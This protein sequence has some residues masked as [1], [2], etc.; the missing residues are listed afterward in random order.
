[1]KGICLTWS[2]GFL[3]IVKCFERHCLLFIRVKKGNFL[4]LT[5][6][7]TWWRN[8]FRIIGLCNVYIPFPV[9]L[10]PCFWWKVF[11]TLYASIH[12]VLTGNVDGIS[13]PFNAR[14]SSIPT[15]RIITSRKSQSSPRQRWDSKCDDVSLLCFLLTHLGFVCC[16]TLS[17][18]SSR[19]RKGKPP[20]WFIGKFLSCC[21][22]YLF[23][24]NWNSGHWKEERSTIGISTLGSHTQNGRFCL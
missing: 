24:N 10:A 18:S 7:N 11:G 16:R 19:G 3:Y 21:F 6:W 13:F 22:P 1:M 17:I 23:E 12:H 9:R 8:A 4:R 20:Q 15:W 14:A 2:G 5:T